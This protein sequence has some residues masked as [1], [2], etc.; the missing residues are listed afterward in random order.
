MRL[1]ERRLNF[2]AYGAVHIRRADR[3]PERL[4]C[5]SPAAILNRMEQRKPES[6]VVF[7]YTQTFG[8]KTR[9][10]RG[11]SWAEYHDGED[12]AY[13]PALRLALARLPVPV[14]YESQLFPAEARG[15][16]PA[17]N[18]KTF[19]AID[20]MMGMAAI[21]GACIDT[22]FCRGNEPTGGWNG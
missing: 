19:A 15:A 3:K 10:R 8:N 6:W 9:G 5:T 21:R 22:Q 13:L 7:A 20:H 17:D 1:A 11:G 14:V 2:S 16:A 4:G 18:Y 12:Q